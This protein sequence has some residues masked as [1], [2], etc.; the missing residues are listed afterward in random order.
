[1]IRKLKNTIIAAFV[2]AILAACG[3]GSSGSSPDPD[4]TGTNSEPVAITM[5][6][7]ELTAALVANVAVGDGVLVP[8]RAWNCRAFPARPV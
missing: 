4:P 2:G 7:A 5:D 8:C 1:M 6:N 3:G